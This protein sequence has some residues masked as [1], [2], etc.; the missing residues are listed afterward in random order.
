MANKSK[1]NCVIC[2]AFGRES[3]ASY[4]VK[5]FDDSIPVCTDCYINYQKT[6]DGEFFSAMLLWANDLA[7][8]DDPIILDEE[9]YNKAQE[10]LNEMKDEEFED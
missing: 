9:D 2:E 4:S 1:G 5:C 8:L 6:E 10:Y 3:I 7:N